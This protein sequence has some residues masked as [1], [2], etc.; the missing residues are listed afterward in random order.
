LKAIELNPS[1]LEAYNILGVVYA[2]TGQSDKA[3][4]T[5][6]EIL[7]RDPANQP[8]LLNLETLE[9]NKPEQKS[10]AILQ[11]IIEASQRTP[12]KEK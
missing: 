2:L 10:T 6:M 4:A 11:K 5:W 9:K 12:P 7:K 8:A 3:Q 1:N